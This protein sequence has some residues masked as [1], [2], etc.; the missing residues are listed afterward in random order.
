MQQRRGAIAALGIAIA[1]LAGIFVVATTALRP[2]PKTEVG[3]VVSVDSVSLTDV[4]AF[5]I[6]TPDGRTVEF[7]I[8]QL[9]NGAQFPP[10]HLNVHQVD[11]V[12]VR[13]TYRDENGEHVAFRLEDAPVASPS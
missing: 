2:P 7:R 1:L 3:V 13:V 4:R 8:G 11:A 12:P 9:E 6:R 10:S 5:T